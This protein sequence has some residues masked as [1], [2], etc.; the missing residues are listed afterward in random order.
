MGTIKVPIHDMLVIYREVEI[1]DVCPKCGADLKKNLEAVELQGY[2]RCVD[3]NDSGE[4]HYYANS[5][6]IDE[7][8]A[9]EWRCSQCCEWIATNNHID[10]SVLGDQGPAAPQLVLD[11]FS[12]M[13]RRTKDGRRP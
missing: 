12:M 7:E 13:D 10:L 11:I 6:G 2:L 1:P 4:L 9:T 5:E 3:T 8:Y